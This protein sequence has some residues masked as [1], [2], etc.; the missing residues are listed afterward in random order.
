MS[1]ADS[2]AIRA[3]RGDWVTEHRELYLTSGGTKGHIMDITPVGGYSFATHCLIKY[4]GRKSGKTY[5]TPLCCGYYAG[6]VVI[7]A[8][9]GGADTHP[10]WYLNLIAKPEVEFQV[11]TEAFRGPWRE[12]EGEERQKIWDYMVASFPFYADYQ[13]STERVLPLVMMKGI[14]SIPV[15][16]LED[17]DAWRD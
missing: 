12:P 8:S 13:A 3:K 2:A 5:I 9:K 16:K 14:D 4:T 11:A 15:F 1:D 10:A 7:C 17:A 6:H